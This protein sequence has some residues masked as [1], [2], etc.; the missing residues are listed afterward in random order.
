MV[1]GQ[2]GAARGVLA[3]ADAC[4]LTPRSELTA[5]RLLQAFRYGAVPL[6]SN[7][8]G[9]VD[10]A[11]DAGKDAAR[12][13]AF[14]LDELSA[15]ALVRTVRGAL[16]VFHDSKRW[17]IIARLSGDDGQVL[18]DHPGVLELIDEVID[19]FLAVATTSADVVAPGHQAMYP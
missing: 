1:T 19:Q 2:A 18:E 6:V 8:P 13:N 17:Q 15:E 16:A 11:V 5:A 9:F 14:V 12:G 7:A 4:L 10:V 3:G